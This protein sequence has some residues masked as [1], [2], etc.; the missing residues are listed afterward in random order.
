M[1]KWCLIHGPAT[2]GQYLHLHLK[3]PDILR[4]T[5]IVS[6]DQTGRT[7]FYFSGSDL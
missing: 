3:E 7:P 2:L 5:S 4:K 6:K 1:I